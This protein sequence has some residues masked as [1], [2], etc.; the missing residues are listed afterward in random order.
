M[1]TVMEAPLSERGIAFGSF[2]LLPRQ[3]LLL[4]SGKSVQLGGRA[5]TILTALIERAGQVVSKDELIRRVWPNTT[6]QESNLKVQIGNLRLALRDGKNGVKYIANDSGRGY[7]FVAPVSIPQSGAVIPSDTEPPSTNTLPK[8]LTRIVGRNEILATLSS[9][10]VDQRFITIVGPGGVGKTTVSLAVSH[11][12][13]SYRDGRIFADLAPLNDP[14]LLPGFVASLFGIAADALDP[15]PTL[16]NLIAEKQILVLLDSC[17]HMLKPIAELAER[18]LN[19][20]RC[21]HVLATSREPLRAMG[22]FVWRLPTLEIPPPN[23]LL[24][25]EVALSF[26]SVQLFVDRLR[27]HSGRFDLTDEEAPRVA[28]ICRKLDGNALAI[29]LA[30]GRVDAFGI[31]GVATGLVD[32]FALLKGG[33]RTALPRH[34]TLIATL[35]WSYDL[36]SPSEQMVL[37]RLSVF[38]GDFPLDA[39]AAVTADQA[40]GAAPAIDCLADLVSKSLVATEEDAGQVRY[41]L[42]DTT[43]A[44]ARQKLVEEGDLTATSRRHAEYYVRVFEQA[45]IEYA[46]QD[47]SDWSSA[48]S[49]QVDNVRA[50][51][52]W[53]YSEIGDASIGITLTIATVPLWLN[54]SLMDECRQHV[55]KALSRVSGTKKQAPLQE[56]QLQTA[57]G[58]ALYSIGPSPASTVAWRRVLQ[59]SKRLRNTDYT[60][61]ALWGLWTVQVTGYHQQQGLTLAHEF[62][63]FAIDAVDPEAIL[64]G[65]RLI[66]ISEHFLG[67]QPEARRH[68]ERM[69]ERSPWRSNPSDII[70]FQFDQ[71]M[72]SR[73]YL[74]KVLWLQ[75]YPAEALAAA[76]RGVLDAQ[77]IGH[78]LSLCYTLGSGACPVALLADDDIGAERYVAMLIEHAV[79]HR[80]AL[81]I[82]MGRGFRGVLQVRLGDFAGGLRLLRESIDDLRDHGFVLYRIAFLG[83]LAKA[84]K[85][86]GKI[87]EGLRI[88]CDALAESN[89]TDE[90]WCRP[91]LMR[92]QGELLIAEGAD[93]AFARAEDVFL[94]SLHL[95]RRQG[96]RSWELRTAISLARL[97]QGQDRAPDARRLLKLVYNAF[98]SSADF[99]DPKI[100]RQVLEQPD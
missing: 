53:C 17:E 19:G 86:S 49:D 28:E 64:V 21:L 2:I 29:E 4:E 70:R 10:I 69:L 95:A 27:A 51:L 37:R 75:G 23:D 3:R 72:A 46:A 25:A 97:F 76:D 43:R 58:V 38:A 52:E 88:I 24:S 89:R 98:P 92:I 47:A 20:T 45:A 85:K 77:A 48:F 81:W 26:P 61:R 9:L 80:L 100:A 8:L 74:A 33:K 5:L 39:A 66:G 62:S 36:L 41:R 7:C 63:D 11:G 22:E 42:L 83:E 91:E 82:S 35:D 68:I 94:A 90:H 16:L 30:A 93:G 59:I 87:E 12:I 56:M 1:D 15:L 65:D 96:A 13:E 40:I 44:Y 6:V 79:K 32:R 71:P 84:L 18:L 55:H 14:L 78:A 31:S 54:L 60:L 67:N 57:L 99:G 73:S 50:A 34:Q